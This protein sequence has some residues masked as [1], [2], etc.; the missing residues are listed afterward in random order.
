MLGPVAL[1]PR[2]HVADLDSVKGPKNSRII[3]EKKKKTLAG[4]SHFLSHCGHQ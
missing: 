1:F 3:R 4:K 2:Y